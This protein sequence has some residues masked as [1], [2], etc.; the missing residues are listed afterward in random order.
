MNH[1]CDFFA[2]WI[3]SFSTATTIF[4]HGVARICKRDWMGRKSPIVIDVLNMCLPSERRACGD[5][6]LRHS[7]LP[8]VITMSLVNPG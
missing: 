1:F 6:R 5:G 3:S 7:E 8:V 2:L 4:H